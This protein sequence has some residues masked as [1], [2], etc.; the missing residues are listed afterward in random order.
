MS[1]FSFF[2]VVIAALC[3]FMGLSVAF[4]SKTWDNDKPGGLFEFRHSWLSVLN[5]PMLFMVPILSVI[6]AFFV[7][8]GEPR[9]WLQAIFRFLIFFGLMTGS[10]YIFFIV[11]AFGLGMRRW[12]RKLR[13]TVTG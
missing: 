8:L 11:T 7:P 9:L 2:L 13:K 1:I 3:V 4:D 5:C 10:T 12:L 6:Y